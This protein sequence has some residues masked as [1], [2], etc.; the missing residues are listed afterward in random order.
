M[1]REEIK[2]Y[3]PHREPML[4]VDACEW[5]EEGV[6]ARGTYYVTGDEWFLQG[7]FPGKPVVPGVI[8]CEIMAQSCFF[9]IQDE[10]KGKTTYFT[11]LNNVRFRNPVV[12][13]DTVEVHA[14]IVKAKAGFFFAHCMAYVNSKISAEGDLSFTLVAGV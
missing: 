5:I 10:V 3:L 9:L 7:H 12:P 2:E 11:G 13:G 8:L 1:N 4:L 14:R 6:C